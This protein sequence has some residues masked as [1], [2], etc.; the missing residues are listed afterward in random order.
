MAWKLV[1][2]RW[3]ILFCVCATAGPFYRDVKRLLR[4]E[5]RAAPSRKRAHPSIPP[6][7]TM[8]RSRS[9]SQALATISWMTRFNPQMATAAAP[10]LIDPHRGAVHPEGEV[11]FP[12]QVVARA[13]RDRVRASFVPGAPPAAGANFATV[14]AASRSARDAVQEEGSRYTTSASGNSAAGWHDEKNGLHPSTEASSTTLLSYTITEENDVLVIATEVPVSLRS[15]FVGL[16]PVLKIVI[17]DTQGQMHVADGDIVPGAPDDAAQSSTAV[18]AR[19]A[20]MT[21]ERIQT[22][23][24]IVIP[25][26]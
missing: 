20:E 14:P 25:S 17:I 19:F 10:V 16:K 22:V 13:N 21:P 11:A 1:H 3:W 18:Q 8:R 9:E 6:A 7:P 5:N 23:R 2:Q 24:L 4:F 12:G 15:M 26:F